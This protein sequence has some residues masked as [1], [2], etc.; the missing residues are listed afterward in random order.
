M[1]C[2]WIWISIVYLWVLWAFLLPMA[3]PMCDFDRFKIMVSGPTKITIKMRAEIK[4]TIEI[5]KLM[6][7]PIFDNKS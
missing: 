7:E 4:L 3:R 2:A 1:D 5:Q 6:M